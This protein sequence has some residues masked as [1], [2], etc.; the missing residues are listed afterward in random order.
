MHTERDR[1][2]YRIISHRRRQVVHGDIDQFRMTGEADPAGAWLFQA[3]LLVAITTYIGMSGLA[4]ALSIKLMK[5]LYAPR[6]W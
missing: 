5:V 1:N 6:I 3:L 2:S 4:A